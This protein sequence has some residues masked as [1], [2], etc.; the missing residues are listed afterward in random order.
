MRWLTV[1]NV[2][3]GFVFC[4]DV[5]LQATATLCCSLQHLLASEYHPTC[6]MRM[7]HG[8]WQIEGAILHGRLLL[9][10]R[11]CTRSRQRL[12]L[13]RSSS[14]CSPSY[15][16]SLSDIDPNRP[17]S[18]LS[19]LTCT[20]EHVQARTPHGCLGGRNTP[21]PLAAN[22]KS[23]AAACPA[24]QHC[25]MRVLPPMNLSEH[26]IPAM[27]SALLCTQ[28]YKCIAKIARNVQSAGVRQAVA[29]LSHNCRTKFAFHAPHHQRQPATVLIMHL[30]A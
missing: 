9:N 24:V 2:S 3:S 28:A 22:S 23:G 18:L 4:D 11:R 21:S 5:R 26:R 19:L 29:R 8:I 30:L 1:G 17:K 6:S 25:Q 12:T 7:Q 27:I 20:D 14:F 15:S 13:L 10:P 16:L